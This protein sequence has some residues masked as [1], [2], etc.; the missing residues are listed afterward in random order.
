MMMKTTIASMKLC[1]HP[2]SH[3]HIHTVLHSLSIIVTLK[4]S[5]GVPYFYCLFHPLC[6][7]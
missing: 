1:G 6:V 7:S 4:V 2:V 3:T 5:C